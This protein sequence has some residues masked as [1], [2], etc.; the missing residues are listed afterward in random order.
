MPIINGRRVD[1][2]YMTGDE[3]IREAKPEPGRRVVIRRGIDAQTVTP[4]KGYGPRELVDKKN[5][6]VQIETIP[7]RTKG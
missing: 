6:P 5:R 7:D 2:D 3:I 4:G 1:K